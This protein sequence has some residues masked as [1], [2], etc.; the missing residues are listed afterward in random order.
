[1]DA[2]AEVHSIGADDWP[3]TNARG[4]PIRKLSLVPDG[5]G[6]TGIRAGNATSQLKDNTDD[7]VTRANIAGAL[8]RNLPKFVPSLVRH[9]GCM[10]IVG[11]GPSVADQVGAIRAEKARGR[12]VMAIK[13][14]H[15]WLLERGI[16]PDLWVSMDSQDKIVEGIRRKSR[17]TCYLVASKSSPMVFDWLAD[18][19][20]ALWHAWMG[21]GEE[22]LF[23]PDDVLVGGGSTSGLR[24]V[25]LAWLLGFSRV[26]LFG[27]DSCLAAD[28][29]K[30]VDGFKVPDWVMQVQADRDGPDRYCDGAMACQAAEFQAVTFAAMPG[31]QMKVVGDGLI[32][33]IMAA[34]ARAGFNDWRN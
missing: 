19:Q 8:A 2:R 7:A 32:A 14:A 16:V 28:K 18:R 23:P 17:E 30:R 33:D 13:G 27:F 26:M 3:L 29:V 12:P 10:V 4:V 31:L 25:T 21:R 34:R 9:D 22:R 6:I 1:M 15:D 20:V 11:S 5:E 24:G